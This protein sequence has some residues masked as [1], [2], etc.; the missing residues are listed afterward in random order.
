VLAEI[1]RVADRYVVVT[2]PFTERLANGMRV[3]P[4]GPVHRNRHRDSFDVATVRSF[5][6]DLELTACLF[7]GVA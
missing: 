1:A 2:V 3:M 5:F 7:S 6:R 4:G